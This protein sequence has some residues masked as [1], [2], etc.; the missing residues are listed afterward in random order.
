MTLSVWVQ[1]GARGTSVAAAGDV[2]RV[3]VA[4]PPV[5]GRANDELRRVLA[6]R[7]RVPAS[8]VTV[9]RGAAS[10]RKLVAVEGVTCA[11][12]VERLTLP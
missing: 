9:V 1:P 2:L 6:R 3:R 11:E 8:A 12:A 4:A 10:R 5:E 7:L